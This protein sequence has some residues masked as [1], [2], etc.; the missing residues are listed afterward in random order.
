MPTLLEIAR[1]LGGELKGP[2]DREVTGI[3]SL[4]EAGP[5]DL[6]PVDSARFAEA[7][8]SSRAGALLVSRRLEA[9]WKTPAIVVEHALSALNR[10]IEMLGLVR[11]PPGGVHPTAIVEEGA[12]VHGTAAVGPYS[13]VEAGARIGARSVLGPHAVVEAGV[14]LGEDCRWPPGS[15]STRESSRGTG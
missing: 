3:A 13:V 6:A 12:D 10:V 14:V 11:K 9:E 7:A 5:T 15:S 8:R 4:E 2:P 1:A